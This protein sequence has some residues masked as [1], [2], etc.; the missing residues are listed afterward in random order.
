VAI[1][2]VIV[3]TLMFVSMGLL[4]IGKSSTR[5]RI[6]SPRPEDRRG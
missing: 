2:L 5:S 4:K 1:V 6:R 3:F